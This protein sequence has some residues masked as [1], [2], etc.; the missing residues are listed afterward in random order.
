MVIA[1]LIVTL[2]TAESNK[3]SKR[4]G[5]CSV[6]LQAGLFKPKKYKWQT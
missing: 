3:D 2:F 1:D 6:V 4:M 5:I